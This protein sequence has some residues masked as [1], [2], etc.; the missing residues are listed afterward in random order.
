MDKV[1]KKWRGRLYMGH[2]WLSM[3]E[4]EEGLEDGQNRKM[5]EE[6]CS[7]MGQEERKECL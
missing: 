2:D 3:E 6:R 5:A 4:V 1:E 7:C